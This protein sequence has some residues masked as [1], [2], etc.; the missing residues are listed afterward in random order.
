[1]YLAECHHHNL[2]CKVLQIVRTLV[3]YGVYRKL[4]A[5]SNDK[6]YILQAGDKKYLKMLQF[7][8]HNAAAGPVYETDGLPK[9]ISSQARRSLWFWHSVLT[10]LTK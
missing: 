5:K 7:S 2:C 8:V 3:H 6:K 9:F 4:I 1:M 10:N